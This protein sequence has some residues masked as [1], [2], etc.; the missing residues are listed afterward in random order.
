MA[1][2]DGVVQAGVHYSR[3]SA[4]V[5]GVLRESGRRQTRIDSA[6]ASRA[7]LRVWELVSNSGEALGE[8]DSPAADGGAP[9]LD[10]WRRPGAMWLVPGATALAGCI[11]AAFLE[12]WRTRG[13]R[14]VRAG[15]PA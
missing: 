2:Q 12:K 6:V 11:V 5:A 9:E 13:V 15:A 14:E 10:C 1:S 3:A 7:A 8:A 4:R